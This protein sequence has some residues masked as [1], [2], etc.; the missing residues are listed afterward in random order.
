MHKCVYLIQAP[1]EPGAKLTLNKSVRCSL[2]V[3]GRRFG[4]TKTSQLRY[5]KR[6][7]FGKMVGI[8]ML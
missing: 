7:V 8:V 6:H 3:A 1:N 4:Q 2:K 5:L